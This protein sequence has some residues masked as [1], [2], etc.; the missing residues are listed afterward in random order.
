[1]E[2]NG[3]GRY[4]RGPGYTT[5][6]PFGRG[7]WPLGGCR[8]TLSGAH[9]TANLAGLWRYRVGDYRV[10]CKIEEQAL[11]L[12]VVKVGHRSDVY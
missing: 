11:V 5:G 12:L 10:I 9:L 8:K 2:A 4:A 6:T 3:V 1:M 7:L